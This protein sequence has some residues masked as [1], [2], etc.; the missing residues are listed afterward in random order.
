[1]TPT[2]NDLIERQA[3]RTLGTFSGMVRALALDKDGIATMRKAAVS[4]GS[5]TGE[6]WAAP[7]ASLPGAGA[8]RELVERR[9]LLDRVPFLRAPFGVPT[10]I[11]TARPTGYRIS[12][13]GAL[14]PISSMPFDTVTLSPGVVGTIIVMTAELVRST[15]PGSDEAINRQLASALGTAINTELLS[16]LTNGI[17][18]IP[19]TGTDDASLLEHSVD[20]LAVGDEPVI[21][22]SLPWAVRIVAALR[23]ADALVPVVVTPEAEDLIVAVAPDGVVVAEGGI[24]ILPGPDATLEMSDDPAGSGELVSMFQTNSVALRAEIEANWERVRD[25]AVVVLDMGGS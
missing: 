4:A 7:L 24:D 2:A 23:G 11:Q 8:F 17:A 13:P 12:T 3:A 16:S 18:A 21:I 15:A 1:M 9:S 25:D 19:A 20:L 22:A 14:K 5:S 6:T 10:P